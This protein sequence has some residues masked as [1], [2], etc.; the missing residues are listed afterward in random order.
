AL[1]ADDYA[2]SRFG[3][4]A[5]LGPEERREAHAAARRAL[6]RLCRLRVTGV[7]Q[8]GRVPNFGLAR[9]GRWARGHRR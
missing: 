2:A 5:R 3:R 1:L 9:R 6:L 4:G 8:G 7:R